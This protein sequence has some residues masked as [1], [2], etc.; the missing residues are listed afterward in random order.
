MYGYAQPRT[1]SATALLYVAALMRRAAYRMRAAARRLDAWI[2]KRRTRTPGVQELQAMSYRELRDIGLT[3]FDAQ[4]LAWGGEVPGR[5]WQELGEAEAA[6]PRGS[7]NAETDDTPRLDALG[8]LNVHVLKDIGAPHW[9]V[10]RAAAGCD[11]EHLRWIG[12]EHR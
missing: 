1:F 5:P 4:H 3:R 6:R 7:R 10:A 12:F 11:R 2:A 9:L 8:H